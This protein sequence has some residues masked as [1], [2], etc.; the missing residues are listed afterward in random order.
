MND[1]ETMI[2]IDAARRANV[3]RQPELREALARRKAANTPW[4]VQASSPYL[5][6]PCR[7]LE[8]FLVTRIAEA[9]ANGWT[10]DDVEQLLAELDRERQVVKPRRNLNLWMDARLKVLATRTSNKGE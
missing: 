7:S 9:F 1:T 8:T 5:N 4:P 2:R 10:T 6:R 3:E